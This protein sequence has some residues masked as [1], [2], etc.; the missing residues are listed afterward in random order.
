MKIDGYAQFGVSPIILYQDDHIIAANKPS[1]LLSIPDG[2]DR[3]LPHLA[4]FVEQHFGRIWVVHR[5]DKETSGIVLLARSAEAHRNLNIQF[6]QRLVQ[7]I[8][9]AVVVGITS[10]DTIGLDL[11][12]R[13]N[14]GRRRRTIVDYDRGK[15]AVT[16]VITLQ[17][18]NTTSLVAA[19]PRSGY[20]H[21]IRAHLYAAAHPILFDPLY[22]NYPSE[23]QSPA[24][25]R[26]LAL[27]ALSV[28]FL[29][30]ATG[31]LTTLEAPYPIDFQQSLHA[32]QI[33]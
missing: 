4:G 2:Y 22:G 11:P 5:L 15:S 16:E 26:R 3:S 31:V 21:Q 24:P 17:R 1:G 8:Y 9:H 12:L 32:A 25:Y 10:W 13:V 6:E 30:P 28:Q 33:E 19:H 14:V 27:H 20:T 7:K 18:Y 23:A 29:H